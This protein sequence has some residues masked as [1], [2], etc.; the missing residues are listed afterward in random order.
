MSCRLCGAIVC[1]WF[2]CNF[3]YQEKKLEDNL[4]E[5]TLLTFCRKKLQKLSNFIRQFYL[6][7]RSEKPRLMFACDVSLRMFN[8]SGS[9]SRL[10]LNKIE[11]P[12]LSASHL[13]TI[14]N[15]NTIL[16]SR[17][18]PEQTRC[19]V[20][21]V[22]AIVQAWSFVSFLSREK[23]KINLSEKKHSLIFW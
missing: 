8:S 3:F 6:H 1:S 10:L 7:Y 15:Q 17:V 13:N 2:F 5:K 18:R 4:P 20:A 21:F 14:W 9:H 22:Q 23:K 12:H 19:C 11:P 16:E